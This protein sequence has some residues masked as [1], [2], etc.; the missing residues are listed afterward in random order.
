MSYRIL[1]ER[2]LIVTRAHGVLRE[3]ELL[4]RK[5]ALLSQDEADAA[6]L[7]GCRLAIVASED[8][9]YGMARMYEMQVGALPPSVGVFRDMAEAEAWLEE[10]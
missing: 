9:V 4:A 1:P 3:E 6:K 10:S 5:R 2:N 8:L 7:E